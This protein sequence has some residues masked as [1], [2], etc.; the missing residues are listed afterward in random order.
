[1]LAK[2]ALSQFLKLQS[3]LAYSKCET[4]Y[5]AMYEAEKEAAWR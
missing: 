3:I 1:M 2:V 4:E 5:V